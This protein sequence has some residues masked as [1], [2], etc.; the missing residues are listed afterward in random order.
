MKLKGTKNLTYT[1]RLQLE[2]CFNAGLTR[3]TI[4]AKLG[5]GVA[6]VYRELRRGKYEH[7]II[8]GYDCIGEPK[9]KTEIRYSADIAQQKYELGKTAHGPQLKL[10]SDFEFVRYVEKRIAKDKLSPC[11]VV[12]EIKR[13]RLFK[14]VISKTTMYRYIDLGL[15]MNIRMTD[16]PVGQ[17]KKKYRRTQAKRP[18]KGTSIECR[19]REISERIAFGHWEMDCVI[20]KQRTKNVLLV[21][22]ERLT[23]Y[24]II[25]KMPNKKAE[26]VVKCINKLEY[27]YG[28]M[29]RKIFKTITV[30]N[31][32]EFSDFEGLERSIYNGKRV[33]VFYCHPYT[34]CE[35]GSNERINR[36]IRR[37]LPKGTNFTP[38][39]DDQIQAVQDWINDYPR[40]V[41]GFATAAEKFTEQLAAI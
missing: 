3:K 1:Q 31:G 6:T 5:I 24:E 14:T 8:K 18:P 32:S 17:R 9:Y 41:L 20:G 21:L 13:L 35:R 2:Q 34:S 33:S 30:D 16:L 40:E 38:L 26:S 19:S 28:K 23:R 7:K 39:S 12:G 36:D 11:A 27:K 15:F 25:F 4:A 10:G 22:T 37:R 29:F